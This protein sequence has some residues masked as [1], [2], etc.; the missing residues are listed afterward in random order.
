MHIIPIASGKGGVGKSLLALNLSV[1]LAENGYSVILADL[2]LGASNLHM[3]MSSIRYDCG[4]G[5]YLAKRRM[6][7][8]DIVQDTEYRNLRFIAGDAEIPGIANL[9]SSQKKS[10]IR[11]LR[12]LEADFLIMDLGAG[13]GVNIIDF[14]LSSGNGIVVTSPT[15]TAT[16]NAY[17]FLKNT[18]FRIIDTTFAKDSPA[19]GYLNKLKKDPAELQRIYIP[20]LLEKLKELDTQGYDAYRERMASFRPSMVLNMLDNPEESVKA[21]K[22]RRSCRQYLDLELDHLGIIYRDTLQDIA[23]NSRLPVVR[24]KPDSVIAQA[25]Y[26]IGD[27]LLEKTASDDSV[28]DMGELDESYRTAEMEAEI[29]YDS[30]VR[31]LEQLLHAGALTE[32]DLLDTLKSQQYEINALK[33]ESNLLKSKLMKAVEQGYKI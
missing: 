30:K 15:L 13:T 26:R 10:L 8:N 20:R 31:D 3:M 19:K 9:Q 1:T 32:S 33:K 4:I 6:D 23:L 21:E 7:F 22:I 11:K 16:L 25:I 18:L 12:G 5:T 29:D 27:K 2:D 14:F 28:I 17:L 24:Y